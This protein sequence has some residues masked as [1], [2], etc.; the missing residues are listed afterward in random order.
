MANIL[1]KF[2]YGLMSVEMLENDEN[3]LAVLLKWFNNN[4]CFYYR[5]VIQLLCEFAKVCILRV[6]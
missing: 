4:P 1:N 2:K 6:R 5:Q 3:V